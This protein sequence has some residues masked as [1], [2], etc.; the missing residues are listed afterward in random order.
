MVPAGVGLQPPPVKG[1]EHKP[2][3][4]VAPSLRQWCQPFELCIHQSWLQAG[5]GGDVNAGGSAFSL[6]G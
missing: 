1:S 4:R 3:H 2:Q 6:A 5:P